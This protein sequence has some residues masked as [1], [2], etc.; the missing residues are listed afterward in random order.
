MRT[1]WKE[2]LDVF[3]ALGYLVKELDPNGVDLYFTNHSGYCSFRHRSKVTEILET[4][5]QEGDTDIELRLQIILQPYMEKLEKRAK[6]Q[7]SFQ[8]NP[9]AKEVIR[10]MNIYV[11]TDGC[12]ED[13]CTGDKQIR[14]FANKLD[15]LNFTKNQVGIQFIS[16][17]RDQAGLDRLNC[18]DSDIETAL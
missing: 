18:L 13:A 6:G 4:M 17:G 5:T 12:W 11:L 16:F 10:P 7:P 3:S 15:E 1:H 2:L 9:R 8:W 14:N